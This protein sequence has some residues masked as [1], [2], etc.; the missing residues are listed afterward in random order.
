MKIRELKTPGGQS[1]QVVG[2]YIGAVAP[3]LGEACVVNQND[4]DIW[5]LI[6]RVRPRGK[7]GL[8]VF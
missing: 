2:I 8:G 7:M 6:A 4:H 1:I 3:Q 5:C